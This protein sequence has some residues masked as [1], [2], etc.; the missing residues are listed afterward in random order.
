MIPAFLERLCFLFPMIISSAELPF[1]TKWH[2]LLQLGAVFYRLLELGVICCSGLWRASIHTLAIFHIEIVIIY[3]GS[4]S[5][6]Q[7][8]LSCL[9]AEFLAAATVV[10]HLVCF[11]RIPV[12]RQ[13]KKMHLIKNWHREHPQWFLFFESL[14]SFGFFFYI[15]FSS[16]SRTLT[17]VI[18]VTS[19]LNNKTV[20]PSI[21]YSSIQWN[22]INTLSLLLFCDWRIV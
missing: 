15:L 6:S 8:H 19:V 20:L 17:N 18:F 3:A 12:F 2:S 5:A 13:G 9:G 22:H 7:S 14:V 11:K 21:E 16:S 4:I 1:G 10:F